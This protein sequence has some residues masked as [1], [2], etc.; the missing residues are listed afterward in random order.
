MREECASLSL[1]MSIR[2][3]TCI[4]ALRLLARSSELEATRLITAELRIRDFLTPVGTN[5]AAQRAALEEL[6]NAVSREAELR[7]R[8]ASFWQEVSD[9]IARR[10][11]TLNFD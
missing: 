11:A 7:P 8:E 1:V 2:L 6:D 4:E 5:R 10:L 9:F 3:D